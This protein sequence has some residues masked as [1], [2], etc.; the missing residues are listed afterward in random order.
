MKNKNIIYTEK[1]IH[2]GFQFK[3]SNIIYK[4][5]SI[6]PFTFI[7]TIDDYLFTSWQ[8]KDVIQNYNDPSCSW[9]PITLP[10][11]QSQNI[12]LWI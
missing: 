5:I 1:D 9:I 12:E 2:V 8:L 11:S 7:D 4:I 10:K 6:N 3:Q